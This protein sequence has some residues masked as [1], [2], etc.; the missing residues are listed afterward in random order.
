MR[1]A[2]GLGVIVGV[3]VEVGVSV[4]VEVGLGVVVGVD[5]MAGPNNCPGAQPDASRLN[6]KIHEKNNI[7]FVFITILRFLGRAR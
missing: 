4:D 7:R 2:V 1:V 6:D 5:V 3:G